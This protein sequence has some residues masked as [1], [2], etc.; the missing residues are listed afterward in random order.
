M[1]QCCLYAGN[2]STPQAGLPSLHQHVTVITDIK[3]RQRYVLAETSKSA[4]SSMCTGDA[5]LRQHECLPGRQT[6]QIPMTTERT[7]DPILWA[8]IAIAL[9]LTV[10]SL[11]GL[12]WPATYARETPYSRTGGYS[13]DLIDLFLVLPILLIS[14]IRGYR[15]SLPARLVWLGTLG[16]LLYNLV[17]YAFGVR[18]NPMFLVYCAT[19]G[20]CFYAAV[21]CVPLIPLDQIA[22]TWG[23]RAPRKTVAVVFLAL[24]IQTV[25]TDVRNDMVA[26]LAGRVPQNISDA[27]Q[28][29][30]FVHVLD[31]AF[32]LPALCITAVLLLRRK[33]AGF[34]LA[35]VFLT[36]LAIMSM[37]IA[38]IMA[39]M[40]QRGF[41]TNFPL[42]AFF[43]ALGVGFTIL[44]GVY[45]GKGVSSAVLPVAR[46][47]KG[48]EQRIY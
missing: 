12:Y 37:E 8:T 47:I 18:F 5:A 17:F 32:L 38:I 22:R 2:S 30:D 35:P 46:E 19:F 4:A 7:H 45:F 43:V 14:G 28:T 41:G 13:S 34:A 25:V 48:A 40:G 26:I 39:V 31:L 15:G 24:S 9:L 10:I 23:P 29:V 6:E 3:N 42:I 16:Y 27:N 36:L 33:A 44:L 1:S 20:L 21:F 11:T